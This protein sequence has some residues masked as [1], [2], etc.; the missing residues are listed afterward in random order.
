MGVSVKCR[1]GLRALFELSKRWGDGLVRIPEIA[2]AQAIPERFLE[3]I[4]NQLRQ[5]GFVESR[6]G[7]GG[8]FMLSR[9]PSAI[10]VEE[11]ITFIDGQIYGVDCEGDPPL[12][13]CRLK[14]HCIFLPLWQDARAAL[15]AVYSKK[16]LQDMVDIE[17]RP[18][19][20]DY[21]I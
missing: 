16:T 18:R 6:R 11:I 8:G 2:A 1:Y 5:G 19:F 15:E 3:N 17:R 7:K 13:P 20:P 10:T 12:H 14:G 9:Q 21:T 4:L